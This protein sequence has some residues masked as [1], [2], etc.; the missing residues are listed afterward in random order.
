MDA[1]TYN[2]ADDRDWP[3][4]DGRRQNYA[5]RVAFQDAWLQARGL[6][7]EAMT[8]RDVLEEQAAWAGT[9]GT[10]FRAQQRRA[11]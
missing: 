4:S 1:P 6:T 2:G 9:H 7:R 10:E 3:S 5:A 11:S 8:A